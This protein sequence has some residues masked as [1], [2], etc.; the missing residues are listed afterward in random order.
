MQTRVGSSDRVLAAVLFTDIVSSTEQS[1]AMGDRRWRTLLDSHDAI[2]RGLIEQGQGRLVKL[3]GDGVVATFEGPGRAVQCAASMRDA[4]HTLAI[5]IRT[6]IHAGEIE[7]RGPDISGIAVYVAARVMEHAG[8][9]EI[10]VSGAV[11]LLMAGSGVKFENRG[12]WAL[13][14]VPGEWPIFTV[15]T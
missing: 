7:R 13:K 11:P 6:G 14:G 1:A 5:E 8:P 2:I 9:G 12:E 3:T 4:L 15:G 10:L